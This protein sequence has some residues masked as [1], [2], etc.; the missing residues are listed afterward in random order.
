MTRGPVVVEITYLICLVTL[1]D[2]VI[3]EILWL[4]QRKFFTAWNYSAKFGSHVHYGGGDVT[5]LIP[6]VTMQDRVI[7]GSSVFKE[8]SSSLNLT[9]VSGLVVIDIVVVE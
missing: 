8:G 7:K 4:Y 6:R 9:T 2:Y 1:Q 3:K 5:Y